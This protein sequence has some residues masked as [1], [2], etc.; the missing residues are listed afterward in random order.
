[1]ALAEFIVVFREVFEI[2]L[3]VGIMLTYLHKTKSGKYSSLVY[4]GVAL[5]VAGSILAAA[6]FERVAGGFEANEAAFEGTTLI[7]AALL[8]TWLN[9]WM[10]GQKNVAKGIENSVRAELDANQKLGLVAFA[11]IAVF[12][13]G[14]E[15]VLFLGGIGITAGTVDAAASLLGGV[16]AIV[17]GYAIMKQIVHL[18]LKTF[19][20]ATSAM[21][22][23]L[24]AGLLS[25]GV[26]ELQEIGVVPTSVEH[27]YDITPAQNADGSYPLMHEKG[28]VGGVLKG[29]AGYDTSPSLEQV[30]AYFGYLALVFLAYR[31]SSQR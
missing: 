14:V 19:F 16:A 12:R 6:A 23:I 5:A 4:L 26:H 3:V 27:V 7:L 18:D 17:L 25:Q 30:A 1:M 20:L 28:A 15:I 2:A 13:E 10:L 21:L 8:V 24:A 11:F 29:M 9:M 22:A 31:R